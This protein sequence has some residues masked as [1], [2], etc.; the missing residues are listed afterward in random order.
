MDPTCNIECFKEFIAEINPLDG[1]F[2]D[3]ETVFFNSVIFFDGLFI[4][5]FKGV[6][7]GGIGIKYNEIFLVMLD[8]YDGCGFMSNFF[9]KSFFK[10]KFPQINETVC[11][12]PK[13]TDDYKKVEHILMKSNI[14]IKNI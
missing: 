13:G 10:D 6:P 12:Y 11:I 9:T 8:Q 14:K 4:L 5:M 3:F 7:I 1:E 2:L